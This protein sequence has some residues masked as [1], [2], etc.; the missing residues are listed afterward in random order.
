L[1]QTAAEL[2]KEISGLTG[3]GDAGILLRETQSTLDQ[4]LL[5]LKEMEQSSQRLQE[6]YNRN[7]REHHSHTE[8]F[9]RAE[10]RADA[11]AKIFKEKL[12]SSRF[13]A[14][15][16]VEQ[17][18]T[19]QEEQQQWT[20]SITLFEDEEKDLSSRIAAIQS[21]LP[22][23]TL[24]MEEWHQ[25]V[26]TLEEARNNLEESGQRLGEVRSTHLQ[27]EKSH[28]RYSE[29]EKMKSEC[30]ATCQNYSKLQAVFRGNTFVE[31]A[32]EE[33]LHQITIDASDRLARLTRGRYAIEVDSS[34]GFVMRDDANGGIKRPVSS[35]SGGETFLTSLALALSL[36]AQIQ[37]RGQHPLEFFFLDE[38]FGT[39][40]QE[41][42]DTVVTAL[43]K[44]QMNA[45]AIGV[46]SHVPELQARLTKKVIVT[47]SDFAGKGTT[48]S[49]KTE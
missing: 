37:L 48:V 10:E 31:F 49:L 32:A 4:L 44:L 17:A 41:L 19:G 18:F 25:I 7:E 27:L 22:E 12:S 34:N 1:K 36:S 6:S 30:E 15:E 29:L 47:P 28:Q 11:A 21:T 33:Q 14:A 35:L 43:E 5:R 40:D 45:F 3:G 42:L 20:E 8:A 9:K 24:S 2:L 38:G 13:A 16:D 39:L 23:R 26:K 46:I